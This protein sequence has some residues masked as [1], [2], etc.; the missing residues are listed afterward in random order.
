MSSL[1]T[2]RLVYL[3]THFVTRLMLSTILQAAEGPCKMTLSQAGTTPGY[4]LDVITDWFPV[5]M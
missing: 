5:L 3:L 1:Q 4:H 2:P